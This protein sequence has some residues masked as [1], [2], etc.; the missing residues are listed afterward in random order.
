MMNENLVAGMLIGTGLTIIFM[1]IA[2]NVLAKDNT[3]NIG[4]LEC[5]DWRNVNY[6]PECRVMTRIGLIDEA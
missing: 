2:A 3:T 5:T 1:L 6:K 4:L